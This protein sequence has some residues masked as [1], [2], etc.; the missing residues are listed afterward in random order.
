MTSWNVS[1]TDGR[2]IRYERA[3]FGPYREGERRDELRERER[4]GGRDR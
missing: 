3:R 2:A 4:E 1:E